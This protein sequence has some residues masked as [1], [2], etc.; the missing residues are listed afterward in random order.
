VE[1]MKNLEGIKNEYTLDIQTVGN[2]PEVNT[3]E[4][5]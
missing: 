3:A 1:A 5:N 4:S 2:H